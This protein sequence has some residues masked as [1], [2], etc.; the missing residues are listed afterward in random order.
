MTQQKSIVV[1]GAGAGIGRAILMHFFAKGWRV[2]GIDKD[3]EA[4]NE[5]RGTYPEDEMLLVEGDVGKEAAVD[6]AFAEIDAWL[7]GAPLTALVNNAGIADPYSGPLENLPLEGWRAW[8]DAS[9]TAAFLCSRA[10]APLL[11]RGEGAA[12]GGAGA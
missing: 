1:T 11:R 5:L 12:I 3:R 2:V 7:A 9:L 8:I 4:L 6:S 10:A